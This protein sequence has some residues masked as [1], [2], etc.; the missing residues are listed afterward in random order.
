MTSLER[1]A[2][3]LLQQKAVQSSSYDHL[4]GQIAAM[5]REK[6]SFG[7]D[8]KL[9]IADVERRRKHLREIHESNLSLEEQL[10]KDS[11]H[12]QALLLQLSKNKKKQASILERM[13]EIR[14]AWEGQP[15]EMLRVIQSL[16]ER[17]KFMKEVSTMNTLLHDAAQTFACIQ[18]ITSG[19]AALHARLQLHFNELQISTSL[20]AERSSA[21]E[22]ELQDATSQLQSVTSEKGLT[23]N[24]YMTSKHSRLMEEWRVEQKEICLSCLQDHVELYRSA[25]LVVVDEIDQ[26]EKQLA[27]KR[28]HHQSLL[29]ALEVLTKQADEIDLRITQSRLESEK[30]ADLLRVQIGALQTRTEAAQRAAN[31]H[32][33]R[34]GAGAQAAWHHCKQVDGTAYLLSFLQWIRH[35]ECVSD[36]ARREQSAAREAILHELRVQH[37]QRLAAKRAY[38]KFKERLL[39]SV[40]A[41]EAEESLTRKDLL[42]DEAAAFTA[43]R[44]TAAERWGALLSRRS[45][46][47]PKPTRAKPPPP[48]AVHPSLTPLHK[49]RLPGRSPAEVGRKRGR[50]TAPAFPTAPIPIPVADTPLPRRT[51]PFCSGAPRRGALRSPAARPRL[52]PSRRTPSPRL[53]SGGT[54]REA[55]VGSPRQRR[56]ALS[57]ASSPGGASPPPR[58]PGGGSLF[59]EAPLRRYLWRGE[60][61][62]EPRRDPPRALWIARRAPPSLDDADDIFADVFS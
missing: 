5:E 9:L 2:E 47:K 29:E 17:K 58:R 10:D 25:A 14:E 59:G 53:S 62:G 11:L 12:T 39:E 31:V 49:P 60:G 54:S 28:N 41:L 19:R 18:R 27:T 51:Y 30:Q 43:L 23:N 56:G 48:H 34:M 8:L 44:C 46:V 33:E 52:L 26:Q 45:S 22:A 7:M 36:Q 21:A 55:E 37:D 32:L 6:R 57:S 40:R 13:A 15:T 24:R 50:A 20:L 35:M 16:Q 4:E 61:R 42:V 1:C 3:A 38:D